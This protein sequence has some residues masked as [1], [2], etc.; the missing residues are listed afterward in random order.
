MNLKPVVLDQEELR[1]FKKPL[2]SLNL[3]QLCWELD[4]HKVSYQM[5]MPP[6]HQTCVVVHEKLSEDGM[7]LEPCGY[8]VTFGSTIEEAL[9]DHLVARWLDTYNE[10]HQY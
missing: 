1:A 3:V 4:K 9:I 10:R 7:R 8:R 5:Y 6:Y 2:E